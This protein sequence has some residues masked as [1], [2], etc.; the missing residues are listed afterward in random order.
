MSVALNGSS[1]FL[2]AE[3]PSDDYPYTITGWFKTSDVDQGGGNAILASNDH[4]TSGPQNQCHLRGDR[5]NNELAVATF[6]TAWKVAYSVSPYPQNDT[7]HHF[8]VVFASGTDRRVFLDGASKNTSS[9]FQSATAGNFLSFGA[10]FKNSPSVYYT[11]SLA[12]VAFHVV[13]LSDSEVAEIAGGTH[14]S[15]VQG[16]K[17]VEY[18][19]LL[20]D[21]TSPLGNPSLTEVNSPSYSSGDQ[22]TIASFTQTLKESYNTND[23]TYVAFG[24]STYVGQTFVANSN[25]NCASVRVRISKSGIIAPNTI[26]CELWATSA[27]KP[28]G[29]AL[30][31]TTLPHNVLHDNDFTNGRWVSFTWSSSVALSNGTTY[32]IVVYSGDSTTM[33]WRVDNS[34]PTAPGSAY[35]STDSGSSWGSAEAYDCMYEVYE[36]AAGAAGVLVPHYY[37]HLLAGV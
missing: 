29:G 34:S 15:D 22:P 16:D 31:S 17:L 20:S 6:N 5:A 36:E 11:G 18:W 9:D 25:F 24:S 10:R 21:N 7:W 32:A 2:W 28:S 23:D 8:A 12:S 37:N 30:A 3:G 27:G 13:A 19:D 33:R 4:G 26:V 35:V 1:Q 14:P